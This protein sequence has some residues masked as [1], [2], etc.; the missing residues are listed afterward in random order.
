MRLWR[1]WQTRTFEGRVG[2]R[3]GSS[4][5]SRTKKSGFLTRIYLYPKCSI[6]LYFQG[7]SGFFAFR[8]NSLEDVKRRLRCTPVAHF[9]VRVLSTRESAH[10]SFS[11]LCAKIYAKGG[12]R[13]EI[14]KTAQKAH[15][16][17]RF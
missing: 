2:N 13:H 5:I 6:I 4:P 17:G 15:R 7:F 16:S 8:L 1:N 10:S 12:E 14:H 9:S 11:L 3:M